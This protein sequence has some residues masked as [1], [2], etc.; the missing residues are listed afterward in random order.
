LHIVQLGLSRPQG[1]GYWPGEDTAERSRGVSSDNWPKDGDQVR[2]AP[3]QFAEFE[4]PDARGIAV[5]GEIDESNAGDLELALRHLGTGGGWVVVLDLQDCTFIDSK[6]LDV[7]VRAAMRLW[8]EGG[9]LTVQNA[10]GPVRR[11]FRLGGLTGG[12]GL[13]QH[14]DGPP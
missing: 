3:D 4:L 6:G 9:Q 13:L 2:A 1:P 8:D 12:Q 7:I 10:R 5:S 14:R 11:L